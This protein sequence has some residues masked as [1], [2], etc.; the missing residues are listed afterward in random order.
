[1]PRHLADHL[2]VI[3]DQTAFHADTSHFEWPPD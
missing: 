1:V 3:D 2:G